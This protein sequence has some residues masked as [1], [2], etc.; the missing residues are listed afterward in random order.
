MLLYNNNNKEIKFSI[1]T[2][3]K[4]IHF[5]GIGGSGMSGI[6]EVMQNLGYEVSGSDIQ[7][8]EI[9]K[10][11]E[12]L[13]CKIT[14]KQHSENVTGKEVIVVSSAIDNN[15]PEL[16]SANEQNLLVVPRAEMLAELMRFS[17]GISI[18]GTHGKTTTT[19]LIVDI[20]TQAKLDPTYIIGGILKASGVNAKLGK[21]KYLVAEADES[22]ISF[23]HL[24]PMLS[25]I[26]NIDEDHME[27][28]DYKYEKLINSFIEFTFNL[29]FY[30]L[31][32]VCID[33]PGV[34]NIIKN[35]KRP[36]I[37][38]GFS[39]EAQIQALNIK[40]NKMQM[41]FDVHNKKNDIKFKIKLNLI[42]RH[43]VLNALAAIAIAIEI[44]VSH[45][46]IQKSM[47][48]FKGVSRRLDYYGEININGNLIPFFDDYGHHPK[49][50]LAVISSLKETFTNKRIVV[51][52]QPHRFSRTKNLL[53]DFIQSLSK[54]G[55]VILL[56]IYP[57]NEKPIKNISSEVIAENINKIGGVNAI[58]INKNKELLDILP[59]IILENDLIVTLGA[60][61]IS[62]VP[63][64]LVDYFSKDGK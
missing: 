29:P 5:I 48:N 27:A 53:Q 55:M 16:I 7:T 41:I 64:I 63:Q 28:Y 8:T 2:Q 54:A 45:E 36:T 13:G 38:Y 40:Q 51:I 58:T 52:F 10:R 1:N 30:G 9:T 42:G 37:K 61:N 24:N 59:K 57:A 17:F 62:L 35:I 49:E 21:S 3:I 6:A 22:D 47:A 20:L 32:V 11:L 39:K 25:V 26:T 33:D 19:S 14:Y 43:N 4:K 12:K 18:A 44:G 56:E 15:N 60:G 23:L 34:K 50:I 46:I 31:C